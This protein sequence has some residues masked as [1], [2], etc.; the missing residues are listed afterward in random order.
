[1]KLLRCLF[2]A[3]IVLFVQIIFYPN[4]LYRQKSG[5]NKKASFGGIVEVL[6][7]E[8]D[9]EGISENSEPAK[10]EI[11]DEDGLKFPLHLVGNW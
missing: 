5:L 10:V 11:N 4:S 2:V 7:E 8:K 3:F 1:M 6:E 9:G